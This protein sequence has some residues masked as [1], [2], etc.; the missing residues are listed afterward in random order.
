MSDRLTLKRRSLQS[1]HVRRARAAR[2]LGRLVRTLSRS[3]LFDQALYEQQRG[4]RFRSAAS[5]AYD[6]VV[7]GSRLGLA[8]GPLLIA[9]VPA[10]DRAPGIAAAAWWSS[11]VRATGFPRTTAHP[12]A[13]P[14]WYAA[15]HPG[16]GDWRGG[17]LAHYTEHGRFEG[18]RLGPLDPGGHD[19]VELGRGSLL[20]H[21]PAAAEGAPSLGT[22]VGALVSVAGIGEALPLLGALLDDASGIARTGVVVDH[23]L[24]GEDLL[25]VASLT[26]VDERVVVVRGREVPAAIGGCTALVV[27]S[28][29]LHIDPR[30]LASLLAD[31]HDGVDAVTPVL[32]ES[33]DTVRDAGT[34]A[35]GV[36]RLAGRPWADA[37]RA[38][39]VAVQGVSGLLVALGPRALAAWVPGDGVRD[40]AVRTAAAVVAD[41]GS[42][43]VDGSVMAGLVAG[44]AEAAGPRPAY[45]D[46][47]RGSSARWAIKSPHPAGPRRRTWGDFHFAEALAA[48]LEEL[49]VEAAVDPLDSWYRESARDDDVTLTLRGLHRYRPTPGSV[50]LLWVISHPEL[51]DD[52]E[53]RDFDVVAAASHG[54]AQRR[55]GAGVQIET[56]L[57]C[58]DAD[59]FRPEAAD[60]GS[61]YPLLFVGNSRRATRP[62]VEAAAASRPELRVIGGGWEGR[63]PEGVLVADHVDNAELPQLY[64]AAGAVLNDH[65]PAM[66]ADGFLSNRL[67]DLT[68]AGARWVSDRAEGLLEVFP[69]GRVADD[70]AEL[71]AVLD[72]ADFADDAVLLAESARIRAE[73]SF[74]ARAAELV[75]LVEH[76]GKG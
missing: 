29:P 14:G 18:L 2:E 38:G 59:L 27:V 54:W 46:S 25:A 40:S 21:G 43:I 31:V 42:A 69:H 1:A 63:L 30:G 23:D 56:L 76:T 66:A 16:S 39:T 15:Q 51:V 17:P 47:A 48:A 34:D 35:A 13:D 65:W 19:L 64:R 10:R 36:R 44:T 20:G 68:A 28:A 11:T 7:T 49:G 53:L 3:V 74:R 75:R 45:A 52:D 26:A 50:N 24:H 33:D 4:R 5:A 72:A 61:G 6:W 32:L 12:L 67:F 70:A 8:A 41:D 73:H 22:E 57:Q 60:P 9:P 58:T 62:L 37:R 71:G 55:S